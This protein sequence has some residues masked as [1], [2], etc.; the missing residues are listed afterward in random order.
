[1]LCLEFLPKGS[2]DRYISGIAITYLVF[3]WDDIFR[4]RA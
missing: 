3:L 1:L 2:L 4:G